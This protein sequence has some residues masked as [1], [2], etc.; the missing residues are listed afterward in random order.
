[1]NRLRAWRFTDQQ[2]PFAAKNGYATPRRASEESAPSAH[3]NKSIDTRACGARMDIQRL[4][5]FVTAAR[6]RSISRA[7]AE[8]GISQSTL[9]RS[10]LA[11]EEDLGAPLL[12]RTARGVD[13][14]AFGAAILQHAQRLLTEERQLRQKAEQICNFS[15]VNVAIG[16]TP[17]LV[18]YLLPGGLV[19]VLSQ[20][21]DLHISVQTGVFEELAAR[22]R[23]N[24]VGLVFALVPENAAGRDLHIDSVLEVAYSAYVRREHPLAACSDVSLQQVAEHPWCTFQ[25]PAADRE[26]RRLFTKMGVREP[27]QVVRSSAVSLLKSIIL[28]RDLIAILPHHVAREEVHKGL[29]VALSVPSLPRSG[30]AALVSL[31]DRQLPPAYGLLA[32]ELRRRCTQRDLPD[33]REGVA[34]ATNGWPE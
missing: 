18:D 26:L 27:E 16:V 12:E 2:T 32:N 34:G 33:C 25:Q 17:N 14:T 8:L 1:M 10:V 22:L 3:A 28:E 7:A 15:E 31:A 23:N 29:L 21:P 19:A 24:E 13:V 5:N 20:F 6:V 9:S 11:L 30:N 4:S